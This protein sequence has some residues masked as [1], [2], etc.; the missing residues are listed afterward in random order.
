M[1]IIYRISPNKFT[2]VKPSYIT[3]SYCLKNFIQNFLENN[4]EDLHIFLDGEFQENETQE[5]LEIYLKYG[6]KYVHYISEGSS[7]KSFVKV[8]NFVLENFKNPNEI[9]YFVENDYLHLKNSK[10]VLE[11]A[12]HIGAY[13]VTLYDHPD[14]YIPK[15]RGGNPF[16]EEDGGELTKI[17]LGDYSH[18]KITNST[19]MTFASRLETLILLKDVI[20][21]WSDAI[22]PNDFQMFLEFRKLGKLLLSPIPTFSTH[23]ETQWL[24]PLID[25]ENV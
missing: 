15:E 16:I 14:K 11:N 1:K 24:S 13:F 7:G 20:L 3:N 21:N 18:Y 12:F 23:G 5:L 25:W 4:C 10:K 19:T 22:Y 2:K 17:Y 9:I 8:F 6:V